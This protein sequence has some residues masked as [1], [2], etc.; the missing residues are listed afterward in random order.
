MDF[1]EFDDT[2]EIPD[3]EIEKI[4]KEEGWHDEIIDE[5]TREFAIKSMDEFFSQKEY[6]CGGNIPHN[7]LFT[8]DNIN[9]VTGVVMEEGIGRVHAILEQNDPPSVCSALRISPEVPWQVMY[10]R[11]LLEMCS[12]QRI[13]KIFAP[14]IILIYLD[15]CNG[16][17]YREE[18][19]SIWK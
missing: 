18:E 17:R 11:Y 12:S 2:D 8:E 16:M 3:E 14:G 9:L 4:A 6:Y 10:V 7:L 5:E 13:P 19:W 15:L 1:P